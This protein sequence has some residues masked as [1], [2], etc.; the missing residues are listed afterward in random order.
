MYRCHAARL[1]T[2]RPRLPAGMGLALPAGRH[3]GA[4]VL[5]VRADRA[6]TSAET[7]VRL[8]QIG[9][10]TDVREAARKIRCPVLIVHPERDVVSP[11]EQGRLL[12]SLIPDCRSYNSTA[13]TTCCSPTSRHG[14]GC[15][16]RCEA[17]S[18]SRLVRPPP[19]AT[20]ATREL[21]RVNGPFWKASPRAS[22]IRSSPHRFDS[23]KRRSA[24]TLP[25]S[26][27]RFASNTV[28]RRSCLPVRRASGEAGRLVNGR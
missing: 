14:R 24:I 5:L 11:I 28:I 4:F 26:S 9:W 10:N 8:L 17:F 21:R 12:A 16:P 3:A 6:A 18:P 7:A 20:L 15:M 22:T 2:R 13:K 27:T 1:G 25:G 23:R 19:A